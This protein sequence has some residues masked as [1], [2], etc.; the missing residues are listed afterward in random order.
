[1]PK[2]G[3]RGM[4]RITIILDSVPSVL[5]NWIGKITNKIISPR[6]ISTQMGNP[7]TMVSRVNTSIMKLELRV[8]CRLLECCAVCLIRTHVSEER[9]AS[10]FMAERISEIGNTFEELLGRKYEYIYNWNGPNLD[11]QISHV[12]SFL[13]WILFSNNSLFYYAA[14]DWGGRVLHNE[15]KQFCLRLYNKIFEQWMYP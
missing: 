7:V 4:Q 14:T 1:M 13:I 12:W 5:L 3:D 10:I 8:E 15:S 2:Y 6:T 11:F 9:I